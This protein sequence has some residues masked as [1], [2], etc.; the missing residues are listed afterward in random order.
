MFHHIVLMKFTD[1]ANTE[2]L[3][4][5]ERYADELRRTIPNLQRYVFTKNIASRS[6]G[7]TH[8]IISTFNTSADHDKYQI[9]ATHV[10][11]RDYMMPVIERIVVC[12]IDEE[13]K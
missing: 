5:V 2:F 10:A 1:K 8:G 12:D 4:R 13:C 3:E 9:S 7:L 11:M 6:D